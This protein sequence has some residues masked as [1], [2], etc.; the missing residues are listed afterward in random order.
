MEGGGDVPKKAK[1]LSALEVGRLV[2]PGLHF[3]GGVAGLALQVLPSGGRSWVLR[4]MVAGKRR[5]MGLGGFPDVTLAGAREDARKKRDII[6]NGG[7]PIEQRRAAVSKLKADRAAALTFEQCAVGYIAAQEPSWSNVKHGQQWRN[8]L[9]TY[10]YPHI[11]SVLVRDVGLP[12]VLAVLEPIWLKKTETASRVRSRV[13]LVLDWATVRGYRQG[14]NPARWRGNLDSLLAKPSKVAPVEHHTALPV[15]AVGAFVLKL[16]DQAGVGARALEF[17]IL[18]AARSG[19]ARGATWDEFDLAAGTWT[20]PAVRMKGKREHRVP[21]SA[22]AL[23]LVQAQPQRKRDQVVFGGPL[24]GLA[25][26]DATLGEVLTRM[27]VDAVPHG[28]R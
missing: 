4:V 18:T 3:V 19:E 21:L 7:D 14:L 13:E 2:A 17:A 20:I 11:G 25:L 6:A 26:S 23:Q 27:K 28:F 16:H 24:K 9:S 15:A 22:R 1:E 5:D 12:Q 10:A 8:T